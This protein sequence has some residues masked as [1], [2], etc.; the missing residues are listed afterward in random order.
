MSRLT[1]LLLCLLPGLAATQQSVIPRYREAS[2]GDPEA[3]VVVGHYYE[4]QYAATRIG[5]NLTEAREWYERSARQRH[6]AGMMY[7][8]RLSLRT[9]PEVHDPANAFY[10]LDR[11]YAANHPE[12]GCNAGLAR[13]YA[14][15]VPSADGKGKSK[16]DPQRAYYHILLQ[17]STGSTPHDIGLLKGRMQAQ[18]TAA[19]IKEVEDRAFRWVE[20]HNKPALKIEAEQGGGDGSSKGGKKKDKD[21]K[22]TTTDEPI[23][24]SDKALDLAIKNQ[25]ESARQVAPLGKQ[26]RYVLPGTDR[27]KK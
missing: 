12:T 10:W 5:R 6:S 16:P 7:L 22:S 3:Q 13:F 14:E 27:E 20:D 2:Q 9:E 4:N 21:G 17:I 1:W 24:T 19:E 23:D 25:Q 11:L 15:G 26:K 8:A 18:L